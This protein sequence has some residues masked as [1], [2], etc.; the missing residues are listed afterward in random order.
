MKNKVCTECGYIGEPIPQL[1][2]S[3]AVD[4]VIWLYFGFLAG[5]SQFLLLLLVPAVWT[6]YHL[7]RFNT[8][9]CPD[10]ESLEMVSMHSHAGKAILE[11]PHPVSIV[12][13]TH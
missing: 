1:K 8:V 13:R 7:I 6:I 4:A 10:C 5:M 11:N 2:S 3:F 12:Y 9:K